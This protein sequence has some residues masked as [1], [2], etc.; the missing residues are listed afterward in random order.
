[1]FDSDPEGVTRR[2]ILVSIRVHYGLFISGLIYV[3]SSAIPGN[4]GGYRR[5]LWPSWF[6]RSESAVEQQQSL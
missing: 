5:K 4:T 1:M 6:L 2:P 3:A